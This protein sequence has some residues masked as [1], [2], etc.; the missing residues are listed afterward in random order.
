MQI[1]YRYR[2]AGITIVK[3]QVMFV[4]ADQIEAFMAAFKEEFCIWIV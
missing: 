1:W 2:D 3:A 4:P